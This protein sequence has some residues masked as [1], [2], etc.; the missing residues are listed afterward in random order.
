MKLSFH[1]TWFVS[2]YF[3]RGWYPETW[4]G[5]AVSFLYV[6]V[7]VLGYQTMETTAF[8]LF[9]AV[10]TSFFLLICSK[11]SRV[12]KSNRDKKEKD[13]KAGKLP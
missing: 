4:E 3:G 6:V 12:P 8:I 1:K 11:K 7:I 13:W 5:W 2:R 10:V 9:T